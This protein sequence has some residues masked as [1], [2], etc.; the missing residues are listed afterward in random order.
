MK[1]KSNGYQHL[2]SS[3]VMAEGGETGEKKYQ[4]RGGGSVM[5]S[6][7]AAYQLSGIKWRKAQ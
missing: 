3:S 4:R 2:I 5:T 1:A 7:A 6:M